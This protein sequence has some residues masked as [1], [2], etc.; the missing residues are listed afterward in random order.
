[1][2]RTNSDWAPPLSREKKFSDLAGPKLNSKLVKEKLKRIILVTQHTLVSANSRPKKRP[3]T[4]GCSWY[5]LAQ[6]S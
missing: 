2:K 1:M 6:G 4:T 5:D 3:S